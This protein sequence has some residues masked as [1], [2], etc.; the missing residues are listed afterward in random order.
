MYIWED[1]GIN[2]MEK[3]TLIFLALAVLIVLIVISLIKNAIKFAL[4]IVGI[5]VAISLF[6]IFVKG[7]SP[8]EEINGY[9]TNIQ[10]GK[11]IAQYTS[12]I[13][14]SV[15]SIKTIVESKKLDE[16]NV[17]ALKAENG[18][19]LQYQQEVQALKHTKKLNLFHDQYCGYLNTIIA[20]SDATVKLAT[21]GG[22]TIQ[23]AEEI[24]S[25]FKANLENLASMKLK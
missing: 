12:K 22:K 5:I 19:L 1:R 20:T 23:G 25:K 21:T 2:K 10:Y 11:D 17:A 8:M 6:N 18:K 16:A 9:R 24:M 15:D 13:K 7:V 4:T 14:S 3:S